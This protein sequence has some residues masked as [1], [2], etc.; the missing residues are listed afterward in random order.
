MGREQRRG[1]R[2]KARERRREVSK[3]GVAV[4]SPCSRSI[5]IAF[6]SSYPNGFSDLTTCRLAHTHARTPVSD[7][8][9]PFPSFPHPKSKSRCARTRAQARAT[10]RRVPHQHTPLP[11]HAAQRCDAIPRRSR[12][13]RVELTAGTLAITGWRLRDGHTEYWMDI[14][15]M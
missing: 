1:G 2:S 12:E 15:R 5:F 4:R 11:S 9:T 6:R 10:T 3:A 8:R 14:Q 7:D 13:V